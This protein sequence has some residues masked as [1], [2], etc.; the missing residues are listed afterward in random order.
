M[1]LTEGMFF[2]SKNIDCVCISDSDLSSA[3]AKS[4][5]GWFGG[6]PR[7]LHCTDVVLR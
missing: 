4:M 3:E 7:G 6:Y 5:N 1:S 2:S